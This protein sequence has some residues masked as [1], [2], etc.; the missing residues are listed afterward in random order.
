MHN[1]RRR[2]ST[3]KTTKKNPRKG[4]KAKGKLQIQ[5]VVASVA[6]HQ[7]I[8]LKKISAFFRD[9]ESKDNFPGLVLR[10][11]KP[12][13][14]ILLFKSGKMVLTGLKRKEDAPVVVEKI[15]DRLEDIG[16]KVDTQPEIS[17][18]NIVASGDLGKMIDLDSAAMM[19]NN[20]IYEPEVFPGLIL[21]REDPKA[22][23]LV[24]SS[25]KIV[26]TGMKEKKNIIMVVKELATMLKEEHL[27]IDLNQ[28]R[29]ELLEI[30]AE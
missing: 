20:A 17:I 6:F 26:C 7:E 2:H 1:T 11:K 30:V 12:K 3:R 13:A 10:L 27:L 5:N 16:I 25:G 4:S 19:L 15:F 29:R 14:T 23:F 8:D 18:Q 22:C 21:R 24:F 28:D 9:V